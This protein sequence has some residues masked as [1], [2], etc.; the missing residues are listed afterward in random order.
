MQQLMNFL[1]NVWME[2]CVPQEWKDALM[3]VPLMTAT[4]REVR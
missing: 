1:V 2:E 3:T 4:S